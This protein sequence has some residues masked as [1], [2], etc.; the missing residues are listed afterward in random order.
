M[1]HK[2]RTRN[3]HYRLMVSIFGV[4]NRLRPTT[5]ATTMTTTAAKATT[6]Q[7]QLRLQQQRRPCLLICFFFFCVCS[8]YS[9]CFRLDRRHPR[10]GQPPTQRGRP[11]LCLGG[12]LRRGFAALPRRCSGNARA[13]AGESQGRAWVSPWPEELEWLDSRPS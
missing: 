9:S 4:K 8:V 5:A 7:Q 11:H 3:Q 12:L 10:N 1:R 2:R 6:E 13:Q